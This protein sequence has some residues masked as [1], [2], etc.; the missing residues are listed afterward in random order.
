VS[1]RSI[2]RLSAV[3][4]DAVETDAE[5]A[6]AALWGDDPRATFPGR[7]VAD[8]LVVAALQFGYP[9]P[10]RVLVEVRDLTLHLDLPR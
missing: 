9:V 5:A 2:R 1:L 8:V 6:A 7:V 10:L 3:A 4:L